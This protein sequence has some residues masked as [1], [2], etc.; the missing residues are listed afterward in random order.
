MRS[1]FNF[2]FHSSYLP[3]SLSSQGHWAQPSTGRSSDLHDT[4]FRTDS[5]PPGPRRFT[6]PSTDS[7]RSM[8]L[9][10]WSL[11]TFIECDVMMDTHFIVWL[12]KRACSI[13][14]SSRGRQTSS[15]DRGRERTRR[16][17]QLYG[18]VMSFWM[19]FYSQW[20]QF[21]WLFVANMQ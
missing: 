8:Y 16:N 14:L 1:K 4:D 11:C 7:L 2:Q 12:F 15:K 20:K 3:L 21:T 19:W 6:T 5:R 17:G 13:D 9:S 10:G 18:G